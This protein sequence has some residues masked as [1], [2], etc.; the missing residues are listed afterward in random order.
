MHIS[1]TEFARLIIF[2][3]LPRIESKTSK[4]QASCDIH[5]AMAA[6]QDFQKEETLDTWNV[7]FDHH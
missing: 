4:V 2:V 6:A 7:Q 5:F 3:T 1:V